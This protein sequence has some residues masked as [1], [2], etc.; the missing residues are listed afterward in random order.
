MLGVTVSIGATT[1][2]SDDTPKSV[3]KRA[4]ELLYCSKREGRNR[5]TCYFPERTESDACH[6]G[7]STLRKRQTNRSPKGILSKRSGSM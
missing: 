2:R 4:D 6:I 3:I 7:K 1:L 5:V